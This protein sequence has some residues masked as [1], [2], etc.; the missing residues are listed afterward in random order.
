MFFV[1]MFLLQVPE[2]AI[3][4][5]IIEY[6][7]ILNNGIM[8]VQRDQQCELL[9]YGELISRISLRVD[10]ARSPMASARLPC[11]VLTSSHV[12]LTK[13]CS[14]SLAKRGYGRVTNPCVFLIA[15]VPA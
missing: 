12:D 13:T 15:R 8:D 6:L 3:L 10:R 4:F 14:A 1:A 11:E 5:S 9:K 7:T 2:I